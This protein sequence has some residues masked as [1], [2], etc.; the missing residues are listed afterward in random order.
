MM[1]S[2]ENTMQ[3]TNELKAQVVE[4]LRN[5]EGRCHDIRT[6]DTIS[7]LSDEI[8]VKLAEMEHV[9]SEMPDLEKPV[10]ITPGYFNS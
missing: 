6:A 5:L 9:I 8:L 1:T 10:P 4:R 7:T 2:K 3:M